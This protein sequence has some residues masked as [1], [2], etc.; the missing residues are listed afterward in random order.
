MALTNGTLFEKAK[1]EDAKR[2]V[3]KGRKRVA[4]TR[5]ALGLAFLITY[6]LLSPYFTYHRI[7]KEEWFDH[8]LFVRLVMVQFIGFVERTKYYGVWKLSEVSRVWTNGTLL[9]VIC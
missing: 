5:G 2:H 1:E 6:S 3:P 8:N 4:Y 9:M 7:L